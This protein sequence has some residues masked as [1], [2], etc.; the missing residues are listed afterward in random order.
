MGFSRLRRILLLVLGT[1]L[2][3]AAG[4]R[5]LGGEEWSLLDSVYMVVITLSS[6]GF[7][8]VHPLSEAQRIWTII[9]IF[10]GIGIVLYA[11][12]QATQFFLNFNMLRRRGMEKKGSNL[13]KH[14][15][16]C[17]YGRMGR[18]IC[19]EME[20]QSLPFVVIESDP[21]KVEAITDRDYVY[22]QGDATEDETLE[23]ANI[24]EAS[25]LVVVLSSDSDILFV[26]MSARTL[27]PDL[28][29]TCRCSLDENVPKLLRAGA[30]KVVNPYVAGGHKM[31]E[32]VVAPYI[33]DSVEISTPN[34]TIDLLM[35]EIK[36]EN[37]DGLN[38]KQIRDS[39]LRE[40]FQIL[41]AGLIDEHGEMVF[42]PHPDTVL[43]ESHTLMLMGE[44]DNLRRFRELAC[45][46]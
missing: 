32:L 30:N 19:D 36:V 24:R 17:G 46:K 18:V 43:K 45:K 37:M 44:K 15:I 22:V 13:K 39:R 1:L 14:F 34:R 26:T 41:I 11:I 21:E 33:E 25:G 35:E 12:T 40:D 5:I 29:I 28:F 10:F 23:K 7:Q 31:A 16:I 42:N 8:E 27:N 38:G 3:G 6:V 20:K 2:T 4:F 9:T